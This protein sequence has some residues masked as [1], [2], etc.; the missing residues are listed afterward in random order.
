MINSIVC[1]NPITLIKLKEAVL[2]EGE[3][4]AMPTNIK[5]L[6][7][8]KA[9]EW[10]ELNSKKCG[11]LNVVI[12]EKFIKFPNREESDW[13][14]NFSY[15]AIE[16]SLSNAVYHRAYDECEPIEVLVE[17]DRIEIVS[18]PGPDSFGND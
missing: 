3:F 1:F 5:S 6:L 17:N 13:F 9:A 16:E 14:F 12:A 11:I 8:G 10:E 18:F 15:T 4:M 7:P 2:K